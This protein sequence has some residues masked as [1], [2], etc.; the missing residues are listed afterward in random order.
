MNKNR[1]PNNTAELAGFVLNKG[2]FSLSQQIQENNISAELR[3]LTVFN[4]GK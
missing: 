2:I 1:F 3:K 4:G